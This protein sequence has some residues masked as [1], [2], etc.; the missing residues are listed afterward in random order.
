MVGEFT[1]SAEVSKIEV[2]VEKITTIYYQ[3]DINEKYNVEKI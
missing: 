3:K 1:E 2:N